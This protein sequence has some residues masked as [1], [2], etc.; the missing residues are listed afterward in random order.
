MGIGG[1][2]HTDTRDRRGVF[3]HGK[4]DR[5]GN[6]VILGIFYAGTD[7]KLVICCSVREAGYTEILQVS[8]RRS[9]NAEAVARSRFIGHLCCS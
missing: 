5:E 4:H 1:G 3:E 9:V 6:R 7:G 2:L 8:K